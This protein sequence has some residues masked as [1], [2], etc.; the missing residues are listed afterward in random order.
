MALGEV[1]YGLYGVVGGL[2][3]F[4]SFLNGIMAS[5]VGRFYAISVGMMNKDPQRGLAECHCWFTTAVLVH[6]LLPIV[7][8]SVGYP[9][10]VWA[11]KSF[12]TIPLDRIEACIWVW[13]F[14]CVSTLIGMVGVPF[15]AWYAA[16]QEIAELTIYSFV[17]TTLNV[18]FMYYAVNHPGDWLAPVACWGMVLSIVPQLIICIRAGMVYRECR[19]EWRFVPLVWRRIC[20]MMAYSGWVL[21]G[22]LGDILSGQGMSVLV[23]RY[24]GPRCN[25]AQSVGNALAGHCNTLS[26]SMVSALWPAIMNAYGAGKFDLM[27]SMVCQVCKVGTLCVLVFAIPLALEVDT[28]LF[29]WLKNPPV[30]ASQLCLC[31]LCVA[32]IDKTTYGYAIAV[33][34]IGKMGRYQSVVAGLFL[35]A[36]PLAWVFFSLGLNV[37]YCGIA[38]IVARTSCA[39]ARLAFS[40]TLIG[41]SFGHWLRSIGL[42]LFGVV[43]CSGASGMLVTHLCSPS[44]LRV[45]LTTGVCETVLSLS[46]WFILFNQS[47]RLF[48]KERLNR[49]IGGFS[50]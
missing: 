21:L 38:L 8:L 47:E 36:L 23:N 24:F 46:S 27:K 4:V 49:A 18:F 5:G 25:A 34:A 12:L 31:T 3:A 19:L 33:H 26:G 45:V 13:R 37:Y 2:T 1:D 17:T 40:R 29:L 39:L 32:V 11:I 41:S 7:L 28:V 10:G 20:Q 42:P 14:V 48:V 44:L 50:A 43:V 35:M 9:V 15:S 22:S 6:T 30:Y 16:K